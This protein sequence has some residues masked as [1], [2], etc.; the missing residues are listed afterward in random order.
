MSSDNSQP[1]FPS[2]EPTGCQSPIL[3]HHNGISLRDY[4]AAQAV[5]GMLGNV[6]DSMERNS[7]IANTQPI[8]ELAYSIA[9]A[10]IHQRK[11]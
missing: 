2:D 7:M 6:S 8:A 3:K 9:D 11:K 5:T 1:A 10:M 4:F